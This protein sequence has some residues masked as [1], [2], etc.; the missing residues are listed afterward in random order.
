MPDAEQAAHLTNAELTE[1]TGVSQPSMTRFVTSGFEHYTVFRR[2]LRSVTDTSHS[3]KALHSTKFQK[4]IEDVRN[5]PDLR[6]CCINAKR[7]R[8]PGHL[9]DSDSLVSLGF[10]ICAP[11][12]ALFG[13]LAAKTRP[14]VRTLPRKHAGTWLRHARASGATAILLSATVSTRGAGYGTRVACRHGDRQTRL[15]AHPRG[16]RS[17]HSRGHLGVRSRRAQGSMSLSAAPFE[18]MTDTAGADGQQRLESL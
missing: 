4:G 13:Y 10:R 16:R 18:A 8:S 14:D 9:I 5:L 11:P 7:T 3:A 15:H 17:D 2:H 6:G 1:R 12:A